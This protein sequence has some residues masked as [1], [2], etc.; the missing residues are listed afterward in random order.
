M[1]SFSYDQPDQLPKDRK[2]MFML[3]SFC[4]FLFVDQP[5]TTLAVKVCLSSCANELVHSLVCESQRFYWAN[6]E[7]V[8]F[9]QEVSLVPY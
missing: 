5:M 6:L 9:W 4:F 2:L 8:R 7:Y 3:F 1:L